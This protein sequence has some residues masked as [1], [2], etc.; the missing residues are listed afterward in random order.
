MM[1]G[2]DPRYVTVAPPARVEKSRADQILDHRHQES[3][4]RAVLNIISTDISEQTF[5]QIVDGLPLKD[6]ALDKRYHRHRTNEPVFNHVKLCPGSLE[7][8]RAFRENFEPT[9]FEIPSRV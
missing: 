2:P 9:A 8:A 5:A 1:T 4:R 3:F 6:V 7:K